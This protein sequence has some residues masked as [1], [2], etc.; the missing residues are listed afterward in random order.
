[1]SWQTSLR[2][3]YS[4]NLSTSLHYTWGKALAYGGGGDIGAWYQ[5]DNNSRLQDFYNIGIEKGPGAGDITH[6]FVS[7]WVYDTPKLANSN[8]DPPANCRRL[9]SRRHLLRR[10]AASRSES[11]RATSLYHQRPDYVFG[12]NPINENYRELPNLQYLN[13]KA[14]ALVPVIQ[15]SGA[16]ARPGTLGWGAVRGPGILERQ[17]VPGQELHDPGKGE[18]PAADGHVQRVKQGE[19]VTGITTSINSATFGQARTT[20]GQ[21][22]IQLNGRLSF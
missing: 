22:V 11:R 17:F 2:K 10:D 12:E 18:A 16:A 15:A 1:M 8:F 3:R 7:E 21:R 13:P 9:A 20:R 5:G 14:F 19:P 6:N 4:H